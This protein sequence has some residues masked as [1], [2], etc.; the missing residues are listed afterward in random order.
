MKNRIA[1]ALTLIRDALTPE[2]LEEFYVNFRPK[3]P[4]A[5]PMDEGAS[6]AE[7]EAHHYYEMAIQI[8]KQSSLQIGDACYALHEN[9]F[10]IIPRGV[11]HRLQ[12]VACDGDY[13]N[14]LWVSITGEVVRTGYSIYSDAGWSKLYGADLYVPGNF[15][16]GEIC[17]EQAAG[18]PGSAAAIAS[19]IKAFLS[20]LLQK[21]SFDGESAGH[22]WTNNIVS[23]LQEYIRGHLHDPLPLQ[24]L[25]G[26]VSLSPSYLCKLFK[27]VTGETITNYIHDLKIAKATEY[28]ADPSLSLSEIAERL[29]FYDQFH[30]S[31]VFKVYTNTSPSK[32]RSTLKQAEA[33]ADRPAAQDE[34]RQR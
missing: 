12:T 28:L 19:Y 3:Q 10:C 4:F 22:S 15:I 16:M 25:S 21:M 26:H 7:L 2:T 13:A 23:E 18:R 27:Q 29:G 14:M 1:E 31:K 20:V 6:F 24:Q 8:H 17:D 30:F 5:A 9:Q 34:A 33:A 11:Q 32:Y